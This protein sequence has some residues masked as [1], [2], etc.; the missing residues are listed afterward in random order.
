MQY[1]LGIER[2]SVNVHACLNLS[3][4]VWIRVSRSV[5]DWDEKIRRVY[6]YLVMDYLVEHNQSFPFLFFFKFCNT[7]SRR[8]CAG[9]FKMILHFKSLERLLELVFISIDNSLYTPFRKC[10]RFPNIASTCLSHSVT[11]HAPPSA[12][13][14]RQKMTQK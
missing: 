2:E 11:S 14:S 8:L 9:L 12:P 13:S 7:H 3:I 10:R 6:S 5:V 1:C 4:T